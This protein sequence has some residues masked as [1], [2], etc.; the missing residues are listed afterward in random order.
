MCVSMDEAGFSGTILYCGRCLHPEY[1][2]IEVLGYQTTAVNL[3]AVPNAMLPHVPAWSV[4]S[5]QFLPAS[6]SDRVLRDM[7]DAVRPALA[8]GASSDPGTSDEAESNLD[9]SSDL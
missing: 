4:T 3:A 1:G 8:S 7:V 2:R 6:H 5:R 9:D